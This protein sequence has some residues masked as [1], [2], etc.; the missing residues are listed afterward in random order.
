MTDNRSSLDEKLKQSFQ[1]DNNVSQFAELGKKLLEETNKPNIITQEQLKPY[2]ALFSVDN[3]EYN[4]NEIYKR[5]I[6]RL[7]NEYIRQLNINIY[8]PTIVIDSL[9]NHK[10]ILVMNRRFT[11]IKSDN[12][13]GKS[14]RDLVPASIARNASVTRDNLLQ[15]ASLKDLVMMNNSPEQKAYFERV[16]KESAHIQKFFLENVASEEKRQE[17]LGHSS[18]GDI[19]DST[20]I[21]DDDE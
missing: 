7:S 21:F 8:E 16:K 4:N 14:H 18:V 12:V 15:G 2:L 3:E 17:L 13:D 10:V 9:E 20:L 5:Q 11:R 1:K 19:D 6:Q